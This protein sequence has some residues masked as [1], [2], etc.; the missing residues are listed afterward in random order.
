[1]SV[2]KRGDKYAVNHN[3]TLIGGITRQAV[4]IGSET[5]GE[6]TS[7]AVHPS[8]M[9]LV[10]QKPGASFTSLAIKTVLDAV[11]QIGTAI[12]GSG[13][14][15]Y[16]QY[17]LKSGTREP[18]AVHKRYT[19]NSGIIVPRVLRCDHQGDASIDVDVV[20]AYD[21]INDP[22]VLSS[23]VSLP[24]G[25]SDLYRFGLG[26]ITIGG[27]ALAGKR[28][29]ELDFGLEVQSEGSDGEIWDTHVSVV[30][31][32]PILTINGITQEWLA[33]SNIPLL[34]KVATH[35]NTT[36]YLRR[37]AVL[38][39]Y[40]PDGGANHIAITAAGLAYID[41]A[42]DAGDGAAT[43]SLRV[44]LVHDGTNNPLVISTTAAIS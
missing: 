2:D 19:I 15:L 23:N 34:G 4:T 39:G 20:V 31:V 8:L 44:P 29:F 35:A 28:G 24:T 36:I 32:S 26:P 14:S 43:T 30:S 18:G 17:H 11:S 27:V 3:G 10:A 16:A 21:G 22:I 40:M 7:G 9:T 38:G 12:N 37:R 33:S 42:I 25:L 5:R 41:S 1:M 13:L 6:A